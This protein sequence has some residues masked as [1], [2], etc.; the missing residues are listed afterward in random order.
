MGTWLLD[1]LRIRRVEFRIAEIPILLLPILLERALGAPPPLAG[2][3]IEGVL[4][5]FFLFAFGDMINCLADRELDAV[6]KKHLS[7]AV[8]RLGVPLVAFQTGASALAALLL[9][10]HLAWQL[11]RGSLVPLVLVGLCLGA[12]YSVE[13]VR[14]KGRGVLQLL[15]LWFI[16]FFGPMVCVALLL[17]PSPSVELVAFAAAYATV[18]MGIVLVNSA[19]DYPE[20]RA[21][22]VR[23]TIVTLGL[24]RGVRLAGALVLGGSLALA[25]L[26]A[27]L[28][29][30]R[31]VAPAYWM[32]LLPYGAAAAWASRDIARLVRSLRARPEEEQIAAVKQAA[33]R[34]P[35]W[36]TAV[37]WTACAAVYALYQARAR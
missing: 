1:N 21:A 11:D 36:I 22:G 34:V 3:L 32:A 14:L 13:P 6:Y 18:Q 9:S 16:L 24:E 29:Q 4:V 15:C 7:Q 27:A 28:Y 25:A 33:K 12:G 10:I 31:G 17:R 8:Y 19:E 37:A 35:L 2:T 26:L 5:F 23:N 20:D 30:R